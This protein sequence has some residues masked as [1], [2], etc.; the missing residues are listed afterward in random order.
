MGV[1]TSLKIM[2]MGGEVSQGLRI[3]DAPVE[4]EGLIP[5]THVSWLIAAWISTSTPEDTVLPSGL[6]GHLNS[7]VQTHA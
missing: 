3:L 6:C 7:C 4:E 2:L 1:E 5:S